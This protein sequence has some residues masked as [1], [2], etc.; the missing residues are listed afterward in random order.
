MKLST[1][2]V[3]VAAAAT[4]LLLASNKVVLGEGDVAQCESDIYRC[5][6]RE[7]PKIIK[8]NGCI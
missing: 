3:P 5:D 6:G 1:L 7:F 8:S 4:F 2:S